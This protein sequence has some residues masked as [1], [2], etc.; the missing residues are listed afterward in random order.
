MKNALEYLREHKSYALT[1][2]SK[3]PL[4]V[5]QV[6]NTVVEN[7]NPDDTNTEST[8]IS[9]TI[10]MT[11]SNLSSSYPTTIYPQILVIV[12]Y[13][14]FKILG[15]EVRDVILY[16]LAYY[17]GVDLWFRNLESPKIRINIH[18]ILIIEYPDFLSNVQYALNKIDGDDLLI[19]IG[20]WL[21]DNQVVFPIDSYDIAVLMTSNNLF[22]KKNGAQT[23]GITFKE[24]ACETLHEKRVKKLAIISDMG[25]FVRIR[26]MAHEIGHSLGMDHD[27]E[28]DNK[29]CPKNDGTVMLPSIDDLGPKYFE[30]SQ[31]S[32]DQLTES[33]E[34]AMLLLWSSF[35]RAP[36]EVITASQSRILD[37]QGRC[38]LIICKREERKDN[39]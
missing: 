24:A 30:W 39:L 38:K 19:A 37:H 27:D 26:G 5:N 13:G 33:F 4:N 7:Q 12:D 29:I 23:I 17:N 8:T 36:L 28:N 14:L 31:C 25:D 9:P 18:A 2:P 22:D 10:Q 15:G 6:T 3:K 11:A 35:L 34:K 20:T 32:L 21:Y 16:I 1:T